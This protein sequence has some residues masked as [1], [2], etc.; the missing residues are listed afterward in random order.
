M[1]RGRMV[2]RAET[3]GNEAMTRIY[4]ASLS[5]YNDGRLHG[6]WIDCDGKD[7]ADIY[8]ETNA[9]LAKS[10][11]PNVL[12]RLCPDCGHYQDVSPFRAENPDECDEC[13]GTLGA[14]FASA[15]EWA[16]HD[17]E[18]FHAGTVGESTSF[19]DIA[20]LAAA[21]DESDDAADAIGYL[22]GNIGYKLAD[23]IE[24]AADV[25]FFDGTTRE[26]AESLVDDCY[27]DALESLPDLIKYHIDYE[28]IARDLEL[29]GDIATYDAGDNGRRIVTNASEF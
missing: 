6:V 14:P 23:A 2:R 25:Q 1:I 18:G 20:A 27:S 9:M 17:H 28:G 3:K 12:R 11:S 24:R 5:D 8:S 19:D 4:V 29:S 22:M 26:Y 15:E 16:I 7:A 13:G 10:K 21:L